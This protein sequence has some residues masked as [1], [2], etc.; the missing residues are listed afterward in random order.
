MTQIDTLKTLVDK[1]QTENNKL[2]ARFEV[3]E[4]QKVRKS[5]LE[6]VI[7]EYLVK[8]R[9]LKQ[10]SKNL[11]KSEKTLVDYREK[12]RKEDEGLI[13]SSMAKAVKFVFTDEDYSFR[14]ESKTRGE[15]S[16][17]KLVSFDNIKKKDR[18]LRLSN[19]KGLRQTV[20]FI[21]S[22]VLL[23]LSKSS[24]FLLLDEV[25]ASLSPNEAE[26]VSYILEMMAEK[27][28]QIPIIEHGNAV[29]KNVEY[30]SYNLSKENS[31]TMLKDITRHVPNNEE[32]E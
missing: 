15:Y 23:Y 13:T 6:N 7:A 29:F 32:I 10:V 19:G 20:R 14:F 9:E 31:T 30:I 4:L 11:T 5:E 1:L 27:G 17:T 16:Y 26:R 8:Y 22:C 25:F 2:K 18:I 24:P 28:F 12:S 21:A 3:N